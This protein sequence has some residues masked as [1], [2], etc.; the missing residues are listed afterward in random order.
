MASNPLTVTLGD[1]SARQVQR[2]VESGHFGSVDEVI[3]EGLRALER[4]DAA[5]E[6]LVRMKVAE[7]LADPRPP[8][9]FDEAMSQ[10]WAEIDRKRA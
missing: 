10:V 7:A 3:H 9:P 8:I 2:H 5:F 4:E 6:E 1:D